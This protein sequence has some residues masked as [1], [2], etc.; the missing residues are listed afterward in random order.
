MKKRLPLFCYRTGKCS[1]SILMV[2]M[3][4]SNAFAEEPVV[5]ENLKLS[6]DLLL[7]YQTA[8]VTI[9]GTVVGDDG[10]PLPGVT[11]SV[12][13]TTVGTVSDIDGRYSI[14]VPEGGSLDFSFKIGR[15]H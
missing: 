2:G 5:A 9:T 13:G 4:A 14:V 12:Q 8:D 1:L 3:F 10:E 6:T 7:D 15:A 11:I